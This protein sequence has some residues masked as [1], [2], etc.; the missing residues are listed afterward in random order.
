MAADGGGGKICGNTI[1]TAEQGLVKF[2]DLAVDRSGSYTLRFSA[3]SYNETVCYFSRLSSP[4]V[5]CSCNC[6]VQGAPFAVDVGGPY[7]L[8]VQRSPSN[9]TGGTALPIQP[10]VGVVDRGGNLLQQVPS[11]LS[12]S[13]SIE[14]PRTDISDFL[15]LLSS[16]PTSSVLGML[17]LRVQRDDYVVFASF[18]VK[19]SCPPLSSPR[20]PSLLLVCCPS[21][22]LILGV[23]S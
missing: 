21:S 13:A 19:K 9:G 12:V 3:S 5:N 10:Q 14:I 8:V 6:S 2:T 20:P 4:D 16:F 1:R 15:V 7:R 22:D 17:H 23:T 11:D 18:E